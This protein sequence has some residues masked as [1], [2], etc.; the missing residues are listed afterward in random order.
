MAVAVLAV[1]VIAAGTYATASADLSEARG[2]SFTRADE[3]ALS[4]IREPLRVVVHLAPEDPRR[5]EL[6]RRAL[7]KLRRVLRHVEVEYL[8]ATAPGMF[9]QTREH[10]GEI[11][12]DLGGRTSTSRATTADGVLETIYELAEIPPPA[13]SEEDVF[14]GHPLAEHPRYASALFYAA[15][16]GTVVGAALLTQWRRQ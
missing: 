9:E 2:N 14:R 16:P 11:W 1:V 6:E 13:P 10:Y 15:W 3:R 12:Y 5:G 8:A 7:S 4:Q